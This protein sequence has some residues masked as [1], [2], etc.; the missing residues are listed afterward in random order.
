VAEND[1]SQRRAVQPAA[2]EP[3]RSERGPELL[4][5]AGV[6]GRFP[7]ERI[8]VRRFRAEFPEQAGDGR[9]AGADAAGQSEGEHGLQAS[10]L[11]AIVPIMSK[12]RGLTPQS[13]DF[14]AW[15]NEIVYRADLADLGPVRGTMVIK[16]Y[17]YALWE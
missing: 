1:G 6:R 17:G 13:E 10:T 11:R 14:S 8:G 5:D 9:F 7:G 3:A 2:R 15:Y 16:P 4:Q 12:S